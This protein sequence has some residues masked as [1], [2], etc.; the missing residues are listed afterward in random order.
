ML[1]LSGAAQRQTCSGG[2]KE[3][4]QNFIAR[5]VEYAMLPGYHYA[6]EF[7]QQCIDLHCADNLNGVSAREYM[8]RITMMPDD[9]F[10]SWVKRYIAKK[11]WVEFGDIPVDE[12][13]E[14]LDE[15]WT[16]ENGLAPSES[17]RCSTTTFEKGTDRE[18]VWYWFEET[19][20][21]SVATDLMCLE[22]EAI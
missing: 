11:L 16:I 9:A 20:N 8:D 14:L 4:E 15:T 7:A 1:K 19:F 17:G 5:F 22:D 12:T 18:Y 13:G 6:E 21:I 3:Y 10:T 2:P